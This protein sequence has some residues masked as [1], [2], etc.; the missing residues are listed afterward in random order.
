[1][2]KSIN[3]DV[4]AGNS[5]YH[6]QTE[7]YKSSGKIVTN[8]FKDGCA[9]KRLEKDVS[10]V[11]EE[12]IDREIEEF[13]YFVLDRLRQGARKKKPA[14][15]EQ[16]P[17]P[18][19]EEKVEE[20]KAG[21]PSPLELP[22]S[23]HDAF[24]KAM[25]P[26]FGIASGVVLENALHESSDHSSLVENIVSGLQGDEQQE[27]R[28][29]LEE[30]LSSAPEELPSGEEGSEVE[31][32]EDVETEGGLS[33]D[34]D[35]ED[36]ILEVL[37]DYFGIMASTVFEEALEDWEMT[38]GSYEELVDIIAAHAD[39]EEEAQELT[40]RLMELIE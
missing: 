9:V 24:L 1:M 19:A 21:A 25:F 13:H 35:I 32:E 8:I 38:G 17:P 3:Q 22:S 27:L 23:L 29:K 16:P 33:V 14:P 30:L 34:S 5:V 36:K 11:P 10:G 28:F 31:Q 15:Q 2:A 7:Y 37:S 26:Y 12:E 20:E 6:I 18:P 4:Y 40:R 39:S